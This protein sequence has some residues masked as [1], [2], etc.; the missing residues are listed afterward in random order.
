MSE[1]ATPIADSLNGA[2]FL[3]RIIE[4]NLNDPRNPERI[5]YPLYIIATIVI[6]GRL[7]GCDDCSE[8]VLFWKENK[9][10]L[11][12]LIYGL[13]DEVASEQTIRRVVSIIDSNELV[14]FM[15]DYFVTSRKNS[16]KALW[17]IPLQDREVIAADG[18]NIR[19]TRQSKNGNDERKHGGYD[20]VSLY[21][22]SYGLTLSQTVV[23][24]KNHEA[25]AI[26]A[27]LKKVNLRNT[28]ITWDSLNTRP[29]TVSAVVDADA[30][31]VVGLKSNQSALED[32]VK[33]AFEFLDKDKYNHQCW[34]FEKVLEGHGRIETKQI[35]IIEMKN[36]V[37]TELRKKWPD[38]HSLIRVRTVRY[39]KNSGVTLP[40]EER[41]FISSIVPDGLDE[42][43]AQTMLDIILKRWGIEA[44][45]WVI[46]VVMRQDALPL[47]NRDYIR[48][49]TAYT[50]LACN[51]L[52]YI[53]D[54]VPEYLGKPWSFKR[55]RILSQKP[56]TA[57][58]FLKA[59]FTE[60]MT[61]IENDERFEGIF[62]KPP[63]PIGTD[64][65][66][67][68][69]INSLLSSISDDTP[70]GRFARSRWKIKAKK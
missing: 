23:D 49:S 27:M 41:F 15:T 33:T 68:P 38:V 39:C 69:E 4:L 54:N 25:E 34:S 14:K 37:R 21:S 8:Q 63:E 19:A 50:K 57:F 13:G 3:Q 28:I 59:F 61:E 22:S 70:L 29:V 42:K 64:F 51:V 9:K 60:D 20:V 11:Q 10:A 32:D 55:L 35:E 65:P 12:N 6:L 44:R 48:N 24:K 30:D 1:T 16:E 56:E 45:H 47:R 26:L 67:N 58:M 36:A 53:R 62:Y 40:P 66:E 2:A 18:Q 52:S 31:F 43:F 46:D 7:S 17:S 5:V